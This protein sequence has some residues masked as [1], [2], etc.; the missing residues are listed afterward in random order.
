M[1]LIV[2]LC[3]LCF[4]DSATT[5]AD[6]YQWK[7]AAGVTHVVDDPGTIP[8]EYRDRVK[9]FH[10]SKPT[11]STI[12]LVAPSRTYPEKSQGAFAQKLAL[13]LGLLKNANE[14]ALGPLGAAGIQP[15]GGWRVRDPL[16][17]EDH[18]EIIAAARRAAESQRLRLSADGAEGVVR[19]A[20]SDFLPPPPIAQP[21]ADLSEEGAYDQEPEVIVEQQPAQVIE[22]IQEP[23]YVPVPV[24]VGEPIWGGHPGR[25]P[26]HPLPPNQPPPQSPSQQRTVRSASPPTHM[27]FGASH[28]PFGAS[29]MPFGSNR[30]SR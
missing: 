10:T 28:M 2:A 19:Q 13:D 25:G 29:H 30:S 12:A 20:A 26:H 11:N 22:V 21:T 6:L 18:A 17:S 8:K 15:A 7:D 14:D 27:P 23:T 9:Q 4:L 1:K 24:I 5:W 3:V 16:T